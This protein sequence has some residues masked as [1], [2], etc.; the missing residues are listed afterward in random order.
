MLASVMLVLLSLITHDSVSQIVLL[1]VLLTILG[2]HVRLDDSC[3][4]NELTAGFAFSL[5]IP[6]LAADLASAVEHITEERPEIGDKAA[7]YGQAF[8]LLKCGISAGVLAG[9]SLVGFLRDT[10]GWRIMGWPLAVLSASAMLPIVSLLQTNGCRV[11][12]AY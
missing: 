6:P 7:V 5:T 12:A 1:C 10:F 2:K 8:S 11:V 4:V 9:P 3:S